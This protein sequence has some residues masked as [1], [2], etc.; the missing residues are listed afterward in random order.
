PDADLETVLLHVAEAGQEPGPRRHAGGLPL[1]A[2]VIDALPV[3][4]LAEFAEG[5]PEHGVDEDLDPLGLAQRLRPLADDVGQARPRAVEGREAEAGLAVEGGGRVPA[6]DVG[7]ARPR[8]VEGREAEAGLA[9]EGGGRVPA[10]LRDGL[11]AVAV[12]P[13]GAAGLA[14]VA[15][16]RRDRPARVVL[17]PLDAVV[18]AL[19][20]P[21]QLLLVAA[22]RVGAGDQV[23][24]PVG[25]LVGGRDAAG[26]L[27]RRRRDEDEPPVVEGGRAPVGEGRRG[28]LG[29]GAGRV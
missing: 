19:V 20:A 24:A 13:D 21:D 4:G 7:Q 11:P 16:R 27:D 10:A 3:R 9:V 23:D 15:G 12:A 6:D 17:V 18:A 25:L 14:D 28:A 2:P 8:A 5:A 26:A 22:V 1:L 29:A